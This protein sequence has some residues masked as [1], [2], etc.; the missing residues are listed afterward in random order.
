M[1]GILEILI[2]RFSNWKSLYLCEVAGLSS[3][4][5]LLLVLIMLL[6]SDNNGVLYDDAVAIEA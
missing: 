5:L 4:S 2:W 1:F 6:D 3:D